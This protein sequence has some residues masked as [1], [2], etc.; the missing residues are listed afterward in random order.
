MDKKKLSNIKLLILDVDGTLTDGKLYLSSTGEIVKAFNIKDGLGIKK[1]LPEF[2]IVPVVITGR[3]SKIVELRCKEL[4]IHVLYQAV[5]DKLEL[6]NKIL[7]DQQL[8]FSNIAVI[9]DDL[10]DYECMKKAAFSGCPNDACKEIKRI[11]DYKCSANG[12]CGA[13]REFIEEMIDKMTGN[14]GGDINGYH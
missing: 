6:L 9:G 11:A 13:V 14:E 4:G 1:L 3:E 5:D 8:D 12:G 7:K 2:N 10:N